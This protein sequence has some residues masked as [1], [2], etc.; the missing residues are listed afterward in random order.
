MRHASEQEACVRPHL[1][2]CFRSLAAAATPSKSANKR[3]RVIAMVVKGSAC[4][5][6]VRRAGMHVRLVWSWGHGE[7]AVPA[8]NIML[9]VAGGAGSCHS[10]LTPSCVQSIRRGRCEEPSRR[11]LLQKSC[12]ESDAA[13]RSLPHACPALSVYKNNELMLAVCFKFCFQSFPQL[14]LLRLLPVAHSSCGASHLRCP[15]SYALGFQIPVARL[16]G[17]GAPRP[18]FLFTLPRPANKRRFPATK[19]I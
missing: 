19:R 1:M 8:V 7:L 9:E 2:D 5:H 14:V 6:C 10:A 17:V 18:R 16:L 3:T 13:C 4:E 12:R 11:K 15:Q